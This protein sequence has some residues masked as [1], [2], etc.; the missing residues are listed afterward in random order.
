MILLDVFYLNKPTYMMTHVRSMKAVDRFIDTSS[1]LLDF[2]SY[3]L[4]LKS[5]TSS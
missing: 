1:S 4:F 2:Y 5:S 3:G